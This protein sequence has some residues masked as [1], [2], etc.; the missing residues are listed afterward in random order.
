MTIFQKAERLPPFV[1]RL[2]A[3]SKNGWKPLS[4]SDI[5]KASGIARSTV[6][7]LSSL[8]SWK[9]VA[10]D[11]ADRFAA[12][13]GVNLLTPGKYFFMLR[14]LKLAHLKCGNAPQRKMFAKLLAKKRS[15]R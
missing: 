7:K 9:G 12:A 2:L 11:V 8:T 10:I 15:E 5:A 6:A 3:R 13:C 4:H 1:C 14:K